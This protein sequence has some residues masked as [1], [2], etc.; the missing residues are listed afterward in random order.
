MTQTLIVHLEKCSYS[1]CCKYLGPLN[2]PPDW[3]FSA[4][5]TFLTLLQA[6]RLR[7]LRKGSV[8]SSSTSGGVSKSQITL[9]VYLNATRSD[10]LFKADFTLAEDQNLLTFHERGVALIASM[11]LNWNKMDR[12]DI[13]KKDD[14]IWILSVYSIIR[15]IVLWVIH[16]HCLAC[17]PFLLLFQRV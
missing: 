9:P 2:D 16:C 15:F 4:C 8:M 12:W 7:W 6:A 10:V 14:L 11:A 13:K 5:I 1:Y 3:C 17:N